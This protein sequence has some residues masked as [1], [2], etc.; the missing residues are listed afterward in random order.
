M[1]F[2]F[3]LSCVISAV[4]LFV[5]YLISHKHNISFWLPYYTWASVLFCQIL[6][7]E[8]SYGCISSR[9]VERDLARYKRA[10]HRVQCGLG[11]CLLVLA[12][13]VYGNS[14][15]VFITEVFKLSFGGLR[16]NFL[17]GCQPEVDLTSME[18]CSMH[19]IENVRCTNPDTALVEEL[20]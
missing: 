1:M 5:S 13:W 20:R 7:L 8:I 15:N 19:Y 11:K 16:P 12:C 14:L 17:A 18:N 6:A 2:S 9:N 10:W 3:T 4:N